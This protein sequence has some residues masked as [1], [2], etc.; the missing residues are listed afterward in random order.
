M[1]LPVFNGREYLR[2]AVVSVLTQE[3]VTLELL[4]IDDG[5]NDD[6]LA[7]L[8]SIQ[9]RRMRTC[10]QA[11]RGL[12]ATLNRGIELASSK[13][14]ARQDQDD[15]VLPGRLARQ[16]G[17]LEDNPDCAMVGT[18][19]H[20]L[21]GNEV[22]T[23]GHH[24]PI[25]HEALCLELLFDNPFVHSSVMF[26]TAVVSELGGYCEDRSRQPPED[27]ELWS[28]MARKYRLANI[29]AV[30]TGYRDVPGSM[31]RSGKSPFLGNLIRISGENLAAALSSRATSDDC[32]ALA[33]LCE[34]LG[35]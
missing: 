29:P 10:R 5:S 9:D 14:I 31:S 21:V 2:P 19:S 1:L 27:Y 4:V 3:K 35:L 11:N 7:V 28:R 13:Y 32:L 15:L 18:W 30:L 6:S 33:G 17:Y 8:E 22:T 23:R 26:R 20:I 25:S 12:A 34:G 16:V 24:Y